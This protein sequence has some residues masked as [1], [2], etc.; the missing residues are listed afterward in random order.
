MSYDPEQAKEEHESNAYSSMQE[1]P[2]LLETLNESIDRIDKNIKE[3]VELLKMK[4]EMEIFKTSE[5]WMKLPIYKHINILDADGW[6]RTNFDYSFKK[7]KINKTEF[8]KRL[9]FSTIHHKK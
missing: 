1:I 9:A 6:D 8:D 5:E 4:E 7:E 3:I 2:D